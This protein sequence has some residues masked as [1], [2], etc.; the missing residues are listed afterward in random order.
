MMIRVLL[1]LSLMVGI[2]ASASVSFENEVQPFLRRFCVECHGGEKV[3]GKVDFL[4]L[5]TD[6]DRAAA[7]ETWEAAI[8]LMREGEMPPDRAVELIEA[9]VEPLR[10]LIAAIHTRLM[11]EEVERR[12]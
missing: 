4:K 6:A 10:D 7:F 5:R 2:E 11:V 9:G 8:E 12:R 1:A 3:K